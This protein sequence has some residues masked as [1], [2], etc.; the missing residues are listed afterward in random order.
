MS[1]YKKL[2]NLRGANTP[3]LA[4]NIVDKKATYSAE[5]QKQLDEAVKKSVDRG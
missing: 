5:L 4:M 2:I 1:K 3:R